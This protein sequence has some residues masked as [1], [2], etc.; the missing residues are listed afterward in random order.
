[1]TPAGLVNVAQQVRV[2]EM[3]RAGPLA[4]LDFGDSHPLV[5]ENRGPAGVRL[6]LL[7]CHGLIIRQQ[8]APVIPL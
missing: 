1:M 4:R 5:A 3:E 2:H 8:G 6:L 7:H